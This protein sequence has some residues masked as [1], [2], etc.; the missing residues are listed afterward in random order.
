MPEVPPSPLPFTLFFFFFC[1]LNP[2]RPITLFFLRLHVPFKVVT[3]AAHWVLRGRDDHAVAPSLRLGPSLGPST[4]GK[5]GYTSSSG[6]GN[7]SSNSS[8]GSGS[9]HS[10]SAAHGGIGYAGGRQKGGSG[11]SGQRAQRALME[12]SSATA[13][14]WKVQGPVGGD[15]GGGGSNSNSSTC[16]SSSTCNSG[17]A[18]LA[19][20]KVTS[21]LANRSSVNH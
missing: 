16:S 12:A 4:G 21:V 7:N 19:V 1:T 2:T 8:S 18:S 14:V 20:P 9:S 17:F 11:E 5:R 15:Y 10:R 3:F 6:S 13:M